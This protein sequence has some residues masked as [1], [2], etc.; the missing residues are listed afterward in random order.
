VAE[1]QELLLLRQDERDRLKVLHEVKQ[2]HLTQVAAAEQL[3]IS[4]RWVR[5]MV[6]R[7]RKKGDRAVVHGLRGRPSKRRIERKVQERAV[8]LY[9]KEYGDFGP[10]LAAEYLAEKHKIVVSKETLRKWLMEAGVWE[11]KPRRVKAVHIWRPRRSCRGE[12]VQWDTSIHDWLEGR[13]REPIKLIAMIDDASSELFARFVAEDTTVEHMQVLR[14]YLE[15]NGRPQAFYT[16][17]A[18]LFLVNA[19]RIG[20]GE[21]ITQEGESQIGRALRELGIELIH[22][23]SP[24]AKGR[25]ERCF[26]TLQDRLIK[27]LRKAGATTR[28]EANQYLEQVFVGQWKKRFSRLPANP[29]DAHRPLGAGQD[30]NSILSHVENRRVANDYTVSWDGK[31]YQISRE[32]VRAGIRGSF[33]RVEG[34][35]D[36]TVWVRVGDTAVEVKRCERQL[37][38]VARKTAPEPRKDH[39][40]G[41][42]SQWMSEFELKK[43]MPGWKAQ[44]I[45]DLA[46]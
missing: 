31:L 4:E 26:G 36:G 6:R 43:A 30:L 29:V 2:G 28:A 45:A 35:L 14:S 39:N 34:R 19:R 33:L 40:R 32:A 11:A 13:G 23:H 12:L 8:Q 42:R 17:K 24:Q 5:E 27:G 37:P 21:E 20:Y 10:T 22:A 18:T 3:G 38:E 15:R 7:V 41:G 44:R 1:E 46:G 9:R 25:V 16:D